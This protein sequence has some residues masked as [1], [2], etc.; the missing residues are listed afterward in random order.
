MMTILKILSFSMLLTVL[1]GCENGAPA[2]NTWTHDERGLFTAAL[3]K[4][5]QFAVVA[6]INSPAKLINV[7]SNN[8]IHHWQHT[9][10]NDGIISAAISGNNKYAI[11]AEPN[12]LALWE[13][14]SGKIIGYWDFP[15]ITDLAIDEKGRYALIGLG[16]N[17]AYY[18][19]LFFGKI[20]QTFEHE[21]AINSVALSKNG[22]F[23]ITGG[24]AHKAKLWHLD[25]GKL[26]HEWSHNFKIYKVAL[27]DDGKY[28]MSNASLGKTRIWETRS[29][30]MISQLPMRYM[31]VSAGVFSP[32]S[33]K[34]LTGRP[35]QRID[36]WDIKTGE[37]LQTATPERRNFW[38]PDAAAIIALAFSSDGRSFYSETSSGIAQEW[39]V[40]K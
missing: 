13:V 20:I 16:N 2:I 22:E 12:S 6:A 37:L 24:L 26:A 33:T 34:L 28:A 17:K 10:S 1:A 11:T 9:D 35:N 8:V 19:D 40:S 5:G 3:S 23:A 39:A 25:T 15:T 7:S 14:G 38:R 18:F 21:D 4:D 29:G 31:T 27:S 32:S 36:I 30:E